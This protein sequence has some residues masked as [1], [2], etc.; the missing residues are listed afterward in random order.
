M[1]LRGR[2]APIPQAG[3]SCFFFP[4]LQKVVVA[5]VMHA[6]LCCWDLDY[7]TTRVLPL[8]LSLTHT[9][10]HHASRNTPRT[11]QTSAQVTLKS[12]KP[13]S[14]QRARPLQRKPSSRPRWQAWHPLRGACRRHQLLLLLL[15]LMQLLLLLPQL[16][17]GQ[18]RAEVARAHSEQP[19][20]MIATTCS[21]PSGCRVHVRASPYPGRP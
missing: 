14:L 13:I 6:Y 2:P 20:R 4:P 8:C 16:L 5:D 19:A 9:M 1:R 17:R 18:Q 10:H 21:T 15:L 12:P 11:M 7:L 3:V